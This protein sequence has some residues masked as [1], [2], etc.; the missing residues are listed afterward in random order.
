MKQK[1]RRWNRIYGAEN[2]KME[3]IEHGKEN[4]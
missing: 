2:K 1:V 3:E 4:I